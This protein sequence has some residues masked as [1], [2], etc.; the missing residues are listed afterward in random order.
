M[1]NKLNIEIPAFR[2][3]SSRNDPG[4]AARVRGLRE[5]FSLHSY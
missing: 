3:R 4:A 2:L 5:L 1:A